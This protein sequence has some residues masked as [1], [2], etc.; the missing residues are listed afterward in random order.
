MDLL[1]DDIA[2]VIHLLTKKLGVDLYDLSVG[3]DKLDPDVKTVGD[4]RG[5]K[6]RPWTGRNSD[7][8]A[9]DPRIQGKVD[10]RLSVALSNY[11]GNVPF[12]YQFLDFF[13]ELFDLRLDYIF[14]HNFKILS[15]FFSSAIR[16]ASG[17]W[18]V[19]FPPR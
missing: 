14:I 10:D 11:T 1:R 15:S 4:Q 2:E 13:H 17:L 16:F 9:D 7:D 19:T 6:K 18:I 5:C 8:S 12:I 3:L